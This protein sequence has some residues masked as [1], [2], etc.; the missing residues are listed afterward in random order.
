MSQQ[1]A[2]TKASVPSIALSG[3]QVIVVVCVT[4]VAAQILSDI[5]SLR[6]VL[7]AGFSTD[8]GTLIY[9][10]TF[11][12]RDMVHK[13]AGKAVARTLIFTAAA[14]NLLMALLFL[15]VSTLP[16]DPNGGPQTEAFAIVL[17][18][19]WSIV[20]ASIIAELVAELIDTEAY[21]LFVNR[22]KDRYQWA[23]VLFSNAISVPI[24]SALFTV[25]AFSA[26]PVVFGTEPLPADVVFSI[27]I[28]NVLIKGAVTLISMPWIYLVRPSANPS[29]ANERQ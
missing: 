9:P 19:L 13:V 3:L 2:S 29:E 6:I 17:A 7:I 5:A 23:R 15:I 22:F 16:G 10:F 8:A 18:P 28:S 27:F 11:T 14:I 4:Y 26:L 21:Q 25:L 1:T 24:D 12:L 20:I